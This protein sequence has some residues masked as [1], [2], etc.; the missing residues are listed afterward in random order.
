MRHKQSDNATKLF[1]RVVAL[2]WCVVALFWRFV[3]L[4]LW[5]VSVDM[6][7]RWMDP[8]FNLQA[9]FQID[10]NCCFSSDK[11][12]KYSGGREMEFATLWI[13]LWLI[14]SGPDALKRQHANTPTHQRDKAT[15]CQSAKRA[16]QRDKII[17]SH[18]RSVFGAFARYF[19]AT[20]QSL[21]M[22]LQHYVTPVGMSEPN[23]TDTNWHERLNKQT[24]WFSS[25]IKKG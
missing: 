4:A 7:T 11:L 8:Y 17:L 22:F 1:C 2:F 6:R 23:F 21:C 15:K 12:N 10:V 13:I 9:N 18:W 3:A 25:I 19:G 16:R 14:W 5:R 20:I 24:H